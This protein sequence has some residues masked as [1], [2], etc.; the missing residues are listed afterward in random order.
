MKTFAVLLIIRIRNVNIVLKYLRKFLIKGD[1]LRKCMGKHLQDL[2]VLNVLP[3]SQEMN[4]DKGT[5]FMLMKRENSSARK[6]TY[7][8]IKKLGT[9][10]C[11]NI[12]V[13]FVM[14]LIM[15]IMT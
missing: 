3:H 5:T 9:R 11:V 13:N 2:S 12:I 6:R 1:M 14:F 4:P 10:R 7:L 8:G 15:S